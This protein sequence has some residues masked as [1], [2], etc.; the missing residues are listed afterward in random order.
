MS[1]VAGVD[2]GSNGP[3]QGQV[4]LTV[5]PHLGL[6]RLQPKTATTGAFI[7]HT[8]TMESIALPPSTGIWVLEF[9]NG[10]GAVSDTESDVVLEL[11]DLLQRC[12]CTDSDGHRW[13]LE[14]KVPNLKA[15]SL[16]EKQCLYKELSVKFTVGPTSASHT[17]VAYLLSFPRFGGARLY[18]SVIPIY[19]ILCLQTFGGA[20]SRWAWRCAPSWKE[21]FQAMGLIDQ[22]L[23]STQTL[24]DSAAHSP[25]AFLPSTSVSTLAV[26]EMMA[27]WSV[28][29]PKNGGFREQLHK[30]AAQVVLEALTMQGLS[31]RTFVLHIRFDHGAGVVWPCDIQVGSQLVLKVTDGNISLEP[32]LALVS[33]PFCCDPVAL[34]WFQELRFADGQV[35]CTVHSMLK[36]T[37][38]S[39]KGHLF[40][41]IV[42]QAARTIEAALY[43]ALHGADDQKMPDL[44]VNFAGI[45]DAI[46]NDGLLG[47]WLLRHVMT[48]I[49][50][51]PTHCSYSLV[52]DKSNVCGLSLDAG[53][54]TF[55]NN[56]ATICVPQA[57]GNYIMAIQ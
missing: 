38:V 9:A 35:L 5:E 52:S 42:W 14:G 34:Q 29:A 48:G 26:L 4:Q 20:A 54:F 21:R 15:W 12:L 1:E 6:V 13:I 22:V 10:F 11:E 2:P 55:P 56:V 33:N 44:Q 31:N 46:Q 16:R 45:F 37:M 19:D 8:V 30:D 36:R 57:I 50:Q 41:Q 53:V 24:R 28:M 7:K 40:V 39:C 17:T 51:A 18:W 32:W 27:R 49:T 25:D 23:H 43:Y 3:P 47:T